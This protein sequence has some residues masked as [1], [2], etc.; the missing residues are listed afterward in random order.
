MTVHPPIAPRQPHTTTVHGRTLSDD[1]FWLRQRDDPAV[2]TYLEAE[3]A[4]TDRVL[5]PTE[6]LQQRLF[7]EIKS[8]I[9]ETD[10]SVPYRLRRFVYFS[11]TEAGK[12]H[13][14]YF[15]RPADAPEDS[16][17]EVLLDVNR[18]AEHEKYLAVGTMRISVDD[19]LLAYTTDNTGFRDYLLHVLDLRTRQPVAETIPHVRS[20]AWANDNATLFYVVDNAAKRPYR[21]FRHRLGTDPSTDTLV[22]EERDERFRLDVQ[23]TRSGRFVLLEA[24]SHTTAEIRVGSADHPEQ[25]FRVVAERRQDH[26]YRVSHR[27]ESFYIRTNDRGRNYRLVTAPVADPGP[28]NWT[29]VVPHRDDVM[30]ERARCFRNFCVLTE[31]TGGLTRLRF[32][33]DDGRDHYLA[34]PE[35]VYQ[36][37][38][39]D[40]HEFDA[41]EYRFVYQSLTT[42]PSVFDFHVARHTRKLLKRTEVLGGYDKDDYVAERVHAVA[43][44]GT[45]IPISIV[46]RR[47]VPRDGTAPLFLTCYGAYGLPHPIAFSHALLSLLERGVVYAIAH[48]RGGSD[49]GKHW[50]DA[51]RM[52]Q[53]RNSFTDFIT[54]AEHLAREGYADSRRM[55]AEGESAG[56]LLVGAVV[57]MRPDLFASTILDVPFVDVLN[58][59]L[60]E[61]LPLTVGEFEEWGN[62]KVEADFRYMASYCPYT[63]L[64]P[65][66]YPAMLVRTSFED[67][68]VMYWE[69]AKYV[70]KLRTLKTNETPLLLYTN[71]SGGH[72]GSSGRYD[73]WREVAFVYAFALWTLGIDE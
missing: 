40:N 72:S 67:S 35:P 52:H 58:T 25:G 10:I 26:D 13:V 9:R 34:L 29:E 20:V 15:R 42:P 30:L 28:A 65:H 48:V 2:R 53:K 47:D 44:D 62:P 24:F 71:M 7:A 1:Y 46:H 12:Q 8:R 4:W 59:M 38:S 3:N 27:G 73:A 50:H 23:R 37:V 36:L 6:E 33:T 69:P 16:A 70:A 63:N 11:Q 14:T 54:C 17:D 5:A 19:N 68:Q 41:T 61:S 43:A 18:L 60:D 55:L 66:A 31:R 51:G 32:L 49:L 21:L 39:G 57:N 64:Q 45:A 56:G 22:Y